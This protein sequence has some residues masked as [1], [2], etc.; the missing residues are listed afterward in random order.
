ME[1]EDL[2]RFLNGKKDGAYRLLVEMYSEQVSSRPMTIALRN[3]PRRPW[4]GVNS[5]A[6]RFL[7][8][9]FGSWTMPSPKAA[10]HYTPDVGCIFMDALYTRNISVHCY[11]LQMK[12]LCKLLAA[13]LLLGSSFSALGQDISNRYPELIKRVKYYT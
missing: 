8:L 3:N 13:V 4:L 10:T 5:I 2:I 11:K 9:N 1:V 12:Q 6:R 7:K